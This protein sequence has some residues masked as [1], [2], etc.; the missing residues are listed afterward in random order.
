VPQF[1]TVS[2]LRSK[3]PLQ[4]QL[5]DVRSPSEFAAGHIPGAAN[6]PMDQIESRLEDLCPAI[7]VVLICQAGKRAC[8]SAD[9]L[10]HKNREILVLEGG[11]HAWINSGLPVVACVKTRWSL[12][13]QVRLIAGV[14]VLAGSL[15]ALTANA[16]WI[17]LSAFIGA[18]LT[19]AGLTD[20]C[21]MAILLGKMPWN[22]NAHCGD[23]FP[24]VELAK[25][26]LRAD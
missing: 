26:S 6:I 2:E 20:F 1:I 25:K 15:L 12:E 7:P 3:Q 5:I 24:N 14:L 10:A 21:P 9:L 17:Y 4:V 13:R 19:F 16:G 18:G 23:A 8:I 11:T 22:R